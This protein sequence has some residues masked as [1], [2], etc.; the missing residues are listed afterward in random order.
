MNSRIKSNNQDFGADYKILLLISLS[1]NHDKPH[2]KK[3]NKYASSP[4]HPLLMCTHTAYDVAVGSCATSYDLN[5][6]QSSQPASMHNPIIILLCELFILRLYSWPRCHCRCGVWC[7]GVAAR[8]LVE[9]NPAISYKHEKQIHIRLP[10]TPSS[11]ARDLVAVS[12]ARSAFP[13][14]CCIEYNI[15]HNGRK[16]F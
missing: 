9:K 15:Y 6:H 10:S 14:S 3:L 4:C 1:I 11:A 13:T 5:K 8:G 12:P 7:H 2:I 16:M